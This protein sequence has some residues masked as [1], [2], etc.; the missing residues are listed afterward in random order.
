ME[1][2]SIIEKLSEYKAKEILSMVTH[3]TNDKEKVNF[4]SKEE[5]SQLVILFDNN[6]I[7]VCNPVDNQYKHFDLQVGSSSNIVNSIVTING[8]V[9]WY[10]KE[11]DSLFGINITTGNQVNYIKLLHI[12]FR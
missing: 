6:T 12:I 7:C 11:S 5:F 10:D 2:L 1:K 3:Y 9:Y 8:I 4:Q